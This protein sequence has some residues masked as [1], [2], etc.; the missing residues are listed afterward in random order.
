M[1]PPVD[2]DER[3]ADP[4]VVTHVVGDED[5]TDRQRMGGDHHIEL[6]DRPACR[7]CRMSA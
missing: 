5:G 3:T 7:R 6:A 1:V 4:L 2:E